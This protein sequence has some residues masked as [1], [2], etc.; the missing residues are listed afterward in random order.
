MKKDEFLS[1]LSDA[2]SPLEKMERLRTVQY[3]RESIEDRMEEGTDEEAA[4]AGM[5]PVQTIAERVI[6]DA[7]ERGALK[8]ERHP[9]PAVLNVLGFPLWFPL[10]AAL[11]AAAVAVY[12][13]VWSV[14][15]SLFAVVAS[16]GLA[17]V[18]GV[19]AMAVFVGVHLWS[20]IFLLGAGFICAALGIALFFPVLALSK[21][22]IEI[23]NRT[24]SG[25]WN[26]RKV[27]RKTEG[28]AE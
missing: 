11:G 27:W 10:L 4:V 19:A 18:A 23:T 6:E 20:A 22:L 1:L 16:L 12:A 2:L 21:W 25:L 14:V 17:G 9:V 8:K 26:K 28:N 7:R 15:V 24:V 5:E 13:A 3:Y